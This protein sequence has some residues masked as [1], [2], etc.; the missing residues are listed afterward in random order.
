[1]RG[2]ED[3]DLSYRSG[4]VSRS[5]SCKSLTGNFGIDWDEIDSIA[6]E[7]LSVASSASSGHRTRTRRRTNSNSNSNTTSNA[8]SNQQQSQMDDPEIGVGGGTGTA[9]MSRYAGHATQTTAASKSSSRAGHGSSSSGNRSKAPPRPSQV[10]QLQ[11][12]PTLTHHQRKQRQRRMFHDIKR[13]LIIGVLIV[14]ATV[15]I[16]MFGA[17]LNN[18]TTTPRRYQISSFT[19]IGADRTARRALS[20]SAAI[21]ASRKWPLSVRDEGAADFEIVSHP[22]APEKVMMLPRFYLT[23]NDGV[24]METLGRVRPL[25]YQR[26]VANLVGR[27]TV[28]G[29]RDFSVRTIF[30]G[31]PSY[32]DEW[33]CRNTLESIFGRAKYPGRIRVGVVDQLMVVE[34]QDHS[35][36]LP[37]EPCSEKPDQALCRYR[38]QIDVYEMDHTLA[39][40]P[41]FSRHIV[42]RLY[43]GEYYALQITADT[44]FTKNWDV[45]IIDQWEETGNEMGVLTTY[46]GD[47]FGSIDETSGV[48]LKKS[49]IVLCSATFEGTGHDRRLRHDYADQPDLLPGIKGIPQLQPFWSSSFSFSRGHFILTVPYDPKLPM[50]SKRDEEISMALRAFTHGYDFYTPARP[51]CFHSARS[52]D[53]KSFVENKDI[54]K[55]VEK[56]SLRRLDDLLGLNEDETYARD[57]N[58]LFGL[59][60]GRPVS[61]FFTAFGIHPAEH[62]TEHKLCNFVSNG[63]MHELFQTYMRDDGMGINY[64]RIHFRF[65][66]LQDNHDA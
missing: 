38:K 35:C 54:Y 62:I 16:H 33:H 50:V 2:M 12:S 63:R 9:S 20:R 39:V 5:S 64:D 26:K 43:R 30:V 66:E 13:L 59:G 1:M 65:H 57:A 19:S 49:R 25:T 18:N 41:T 37:I 22:V 29:S 11:Q 10:R 34:G 48:L 51:V 8:N 53:L 6:E 61:K 7:S 3:D 60:Q 58:E 15:S 23:R 24:T 21:Y 56:F 4:S 47:T 14:T 32:R 31:L 46:L 27:T 55:G 28:E 40:G 42:N 36:D 17:Y 44:T 45:D 52:D